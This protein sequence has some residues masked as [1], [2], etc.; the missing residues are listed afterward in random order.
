[1]F[2][3]TNHNLNKLSY[4][5]AILFI[6]IGGIQQYLTPYFNSLG[7]SNVGFNILLIIYISIFLSNFSASFFINK[8]GIKKL[9]IVTA[10]L[11]LFSMILILF[12]NEYIAYLGAMILGLGGAVLWNSQNGYL[13]KISS[14]KNRGENSGFFISIFQTG[15]LLSVLVLGFIVEIYGFET[16]FLIVLGIGFLSLLLFMKLDDTE[17]SQ[18]SKKTF[19]FS[20]KTPTLFKVSIMNAFSYHLIYGLSFSLVPLHIYLLTKSTFIVAM[21]SSLFYLFPMLFSKKVGV[22]SDKKGRSYIAFLGASFSILGLLFFHF[23]DELFVLIIAS[24]LLALSLTFFNP[25]F[26][27]LQ[28]DISTPDTQVYVTNIFMFFKYM[29]VIVGIALGMLLGME[30]AYVVMMS[31]VLIGLL[32]GYKLMLDMPL[33][34]MKIGK[35]IDFILKQ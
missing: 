15:S 2:L 25:V 23:S 32:L 22:Y 6:A 21:V 33:L 26:I 20:F 28:G 9:L 27:A 24:T 7:Q 17:A 34:K 19:S 35:E 13:L 14:E 12:T 29:G 11:Y 18:Q 16:S 10:L 3:T 4:G 31:L 8:F 1:M 5:F 30:L